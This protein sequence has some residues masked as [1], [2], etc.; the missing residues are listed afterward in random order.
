VHV[1]EY[2]QVMTSLTTWIC[3]Y[4][5]YQR[6]YR[7]HG[8][9][10][11]IVCLR[12]A[13]ICTLETGNMETLSHVYPLFRRKQGKWDWF[14]TNGKESTAYISSLKTNRFLGLL[15]VCNCSNLM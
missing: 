4:E 14:R 5:H 2:L 10:D 8:D 11:L 13:A 7:Y 12:S 15:N 6:E 1:I 3:K 9:S